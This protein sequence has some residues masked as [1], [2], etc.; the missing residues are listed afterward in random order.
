MKDTDSA[1]LTGKLLLAT[2]SINDPRFHRSVIL[3]TAHDPQGAMGMI[4]NYPLPDL[5]F[6]GLLDQLGLVSDIKINPDELDLPVLSGGPVEGQR[7][8]V[9]HSTDFKQDDTVEI[10]EQFSVTGTT[11][12]LKEI[13]RGNGPDHALFILGYAGWQA[14]QLEA[15][16]QENSWLVADP[17]PALIFHGK[18]EEKWTMAIGKLGFDPGMLSGETGR[19]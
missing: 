8:F 13:V 7:G 6:K 19:A 1:Y 18:P 5:E 3:I 4:V 16:L 11:D 9:L 14:G 2:P 17:D 10:D 15:E 12:A